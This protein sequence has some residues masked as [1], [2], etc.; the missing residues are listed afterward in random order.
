MKDHEGHIVKSKKEL[1]KWNN[2]LLSTETSDVFGIK[3]DNSTGWLSVGGP[4][5]GSYATKLGEHIFYDYISDFGLRVGDPCQAVDNKL[6]IDLNPR[7]TTVKD[8]KYHE[9]TDSQF[10]LPKVC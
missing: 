2:D 9:G 5:K 8:M 10:W 3:T 1:Y 7:H 4:I 6:N